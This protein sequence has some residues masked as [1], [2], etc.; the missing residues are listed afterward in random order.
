MK[1]K[2]EKLVLEKLWKFYLS[3]FI[4]MREILDEFFSHKETERT[5]FLK[6]FAH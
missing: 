4:L 5:C 2:Q 6:Y 3:R 1:E